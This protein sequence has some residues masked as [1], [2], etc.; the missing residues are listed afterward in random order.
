LAKS[1]IL[2]G[3]ST[4]TSHNIVSHGLGI[5]DAQTNLPARG[6]TS[7][8]LTTRSPTLQTCPHVVQHK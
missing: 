4:F 2:Q 7:T 1:L 3:F 6:P 8:N 5:Y